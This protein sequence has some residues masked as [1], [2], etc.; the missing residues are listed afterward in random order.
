[1]VSQSPGLT[2]RITTTM[3]IVAAGRQW[4][5]MLF[6]ARNCGVMEGNRG[7]AT[8]GEFRP[9]IPSMAR[10]YDYYLGGCFL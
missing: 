8:D 9:D 10:M 5:Q 7:M 4:P 6:S 3:S 1:M 2:S